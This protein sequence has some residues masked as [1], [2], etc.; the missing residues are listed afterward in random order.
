MITIDENGENL[1]LKVKR[2]N[3]HMRLDRITFQ[4]LTKSYSGRY[5]MMLYGKKWGSIRN[6]F[7]A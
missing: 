7:K 6:D 2:T 5:S 4:V 3:S 1:K